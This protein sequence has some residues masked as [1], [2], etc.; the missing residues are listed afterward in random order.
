MNTYT[1]TTEQL[2]N[3]NVRYRIFK[4]GKELAHKRGIKNTLEAAE[5]RAQTV[6]EDHKALLDSFDDDYGLTNEQGMGFGAEDAEDAE[7]KATTPRTRYVEDEFG[8]DIVQEVEI[9]E[10]V[11]GGLE[12]ETDD[13]VESVEDIRT[14]IE[15]D[16]ASYDEVIAEIRKHIDNAGDEVRLTIVEGAGPHEWIS[17]WVGIEAHPTEDGE[18]RVQDTGFTDVWENKSEAIEAM[19]V[20]FYNWHAEDIAQER[21]REQ[22]EREHQAE[23]DM[24]NSMTPEER[25]DYLGYPK[26]IPEDGNGS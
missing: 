16:E 9:I 1:Y 2:S 26:T 7:H 10:D 19:V 18:W 17:T 6:I 5:A 8:E 25:G 14:M 13:A 15:A 12:L 21:E 3:G 24:L 22:E 23:A 4:D 20:S 11:D